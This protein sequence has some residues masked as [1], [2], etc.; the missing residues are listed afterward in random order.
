MENFPPPDLA[1]KLIESY[2]YNVNLMFPIL[3]RVTFDRQWADGLYCRDAYFAAVCM[4]IFSVASRWSDDPRVLG[5]SSSACGSS[6]PQF[7][8][9]NS[10]WGLAGWNFCTPALGTLFPALVDSQFTSE[11]KFRVF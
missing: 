6:S 3:H 10:P 1:Q 8:S 4:A 11:L 9:N 2:F 7:N 5:L